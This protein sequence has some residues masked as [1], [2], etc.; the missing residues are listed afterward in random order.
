M[1]APKYIGHRGIQSTL[2]TC[3]N[4]FFCPHIKHNVTQF[5]S[6]CIVCQRVKKYHGKTHKLLMLLPIPK[7][8]WEEIYMDFVINM[9]PNSYDMDYC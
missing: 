7:D 4:Y 2:T 8:P 9:P 3:N 6:Q 5:V 1:H